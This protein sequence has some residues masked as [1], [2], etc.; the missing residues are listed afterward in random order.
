MD[1]IERY[2][3]LLIDI[4]G[5]VRVGDR[6][7]PD[8]VEAIVELAARGI[9]YGF[10]TNSPR[11]TPGQHAEELREGGVPVPEGRVVTSAETL[12][13]FILAEAGEGARAVVVG[14]DSFHGQVA[15]AGIEEVPPD[16]WES[17]AAVMVSGH[18]G[19]DYREM[20]AAAMAARAG[21]LLAAT[22]QDPT[23]PMEDGHWPGTGAIVAAI[24]TASG[25]EAV[26]TGKPSPP[27]F[28]AG[29]EA[30]GRPKR[31]AMIGDRADTDVAGAQAVGM[32]GILLTLPDSPAGQPEVTWVAPDHRIE[33][34]LDL[35]G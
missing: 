10:V 28:E 5:V 6:F 34:L 35:F 20:K 19:F 15:Q 32:E 17:A 9:P 3:G 16:D 30:I 22:G 2:D 14:T 21:A 29:L 12:I 11:L 24:E 8:S 18:D 1:L 31:A 27:I 26:I 4:D 25:V 23:M 7:V 13:S 33:S